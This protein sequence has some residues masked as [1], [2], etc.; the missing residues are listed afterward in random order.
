MGDLIHLLPDRGQEGDTYTV[1]VEVR[2]SLRAFAQVMELA[3]RKADR[4]AG[5]Q[6][7]WKGQNLLYLFALLMGSQARLYGALY[8]QGDPAIEAGELGALAFA[9]WDEV[10]CKTGS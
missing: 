2:P 5:N 4:E 8:G 7:C 1:E 10:R 3:L 6:D 9:I